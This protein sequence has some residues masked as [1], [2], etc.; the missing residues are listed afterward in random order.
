M[1]KKLFISS[2]TAVLAGALFFLMSCANSSAASSGNGGSNNTNSTG[3]I[4]ENG[5]YLDHDDG[6]TL[7]MFLCEELCEDDEETVRLCF[8]EDGAVK[9][10][11]TNLDESKYGTRYDKIRGTYTG[12]PLADGELQI[13]FTEKTHGHGSHYEAYNKEANLT[14]YIT[15][16]VL[17]F[18][19]GEF[20]YGDF[21]HYDFIRTTPDDLGPYI[22]AGISNRQNDNT[23]T[24]WTIPEGYTSV[25]ASC[26]YDHGASG[27]YKYL[28][29]VNLPST[30]KKIEGSAFFNCTALEEIKIPEGCT[31][32]G[33]YAFYDCT[34][35]KELIIP[36]TI[37]ELSNFALIDF[38]VP[39]RF[40][41]GTEKIDEIGDKTFIYMKE[42]NIPSTLKQINNINIDFSS[43]TTIN[44]D[45][46][47]YD[48]CNFIGNN[49]ISRNAKVTCKNIDC[50]DI[51]NYTLDD[52]LT[53]YQ[54]EE[55]GK[56]DGI[57][58]TLKKN[59]T[60]IK[61]SVDGFEKGVWSVDKDSSNKITFY[62][63]NGNAVTYDYSYS[64]NY[65]AADGEKYNLE[66]TGL[67]DFNEVTN[68]KVIEK[69]KTT[70]DK[71]CENAVKNGEGK[72][73]Y[74]QYYIEK[75]PGY[76]QYVDT[77]VSYKI[78]DENF[79]V[80]YYED[81]YY[82]SCKAKIEELLGNNTYNYSSRE[83]SV[84]DLTED[85]QK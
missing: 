81:R 3:G 73:I 8:Y 30:I 78:K 17:R 49:S 4:Y 70:T 13:N 18:K 42:L 80:Y 22:H 48:L 1:S 68:F 45:G 46:S 50:S 29:K 5:Y 55:T 59:K 52:R 40:S 63:D 66:I 85:P 10:R 2:V 16:N 54:W 65:Y 61:E 36:S 75:A 47:L 7:A 74:Y 32:I 58:L 35:L 14:A 28:N 31:E 11:I 60:Y 67:A 33:G 57:L 27:Y 53:A 19:N 20:G 37:K 64:Q 15:K 41:E 71:W 26:F 82:K 44:S 6:N 51:V 25:A 62:S 69:Q 72:Y 76:I 79:Y 38:Q 39:V 12:N 84:L 77:P 43:I 34:S 9:L 23:I 56:T 24:E 83:R 21:H